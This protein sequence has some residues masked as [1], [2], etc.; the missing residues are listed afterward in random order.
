MDPTSLLSL[1]NRPGFRHDRRG[2]VLSIPLMDYEAAREL[3]WRLH[4]ERL[5]DRRPDTLVLLEHEPVMTLGRTT[6]TAHWNG[7]RKAPG[8]R[9]LRVIESERGGSVTYHGPGQ[10]VGYPIVKLRQFCAGPKAYVRMLEDVLIRVLAEWGIEG[11]RTDRFV[12]VW[13]N[14]PDDPNGPPAKIA[15]IGVKIARGVTLHG[16]ALNATVDL[17]PFAG[18]MPCGLEGCRVTSMAEVLPK[19]VAPDEVRRQITRCFGDVFGLDWEDSPLQAPSAAHVNIRAGHVPG[20][21]G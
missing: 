2:V 10:I 3:Q 9:G 19:E 14:D 1:P 13:V 12:G 11:Y 8:A 4:E 16:F 5:A 7:M 17:E 18:I 20:L 6:K 15:S 21:V